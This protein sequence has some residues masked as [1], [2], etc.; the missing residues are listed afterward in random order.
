MASTEGADSK[1]QCALCEDEASRF[2]NIDVNGQVQAL[3]VCE[4]C[5]ADIEG[6]REQESL[7]ASLVR[8]DE[9]DEK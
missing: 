2:A 8:L 3:P 1:V 4:D 5:F 6:S 9:D 7:G